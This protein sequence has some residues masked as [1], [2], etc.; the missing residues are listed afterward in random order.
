MTGGTAGDVTA[1]N[2]DA[3]IDGGAVVGTVTASGTVSVENAQ[4]GTLDG[5]VVNT[6]GATVTGNVEADTDASLT[7]GSVSGN[8]NVTD[9]AATIT[10]TEI[11]GTVTADSV[12]MTGGTAGAV[13]ADNGNATIDGG[14]VVGDVT[15]IGTVS[16]DNAAAGAVSAKD[17][18]LN[19]AVTGVVT[20]TDSAIISGGSVNGD[21]TA[22]AAMI[23]DAEIVGNVAAETVNMKRATTGDVTG[24]DVVIDLASRVDGSVNGKDVTIADSFISDSVSGDEVSLF[25]GAW[26]NGDVNA[27]ALYAEGNVNAAAISAD[28]MDLLD[29]ELVADSLNV[30]GAA[31]ISNASVTAETLAADSVTGDNA[32][33]NAAVT[34]G[35]VTLTNSSAKD[36]TMTG[37]LVASGSAIGSVSGAASAVITGGSTGDLSV[38]GD[39]TATNGADIAS[40]SNADDVTLAQAVTGDISATGKVNATTGT[41]MGDVTSGSAAMSGAK[42]KSL[43]TGALSV[44]SEGFVADADISADGVVSIAGSTTAGKSISLKGSAGSAISGADITAGDKLTLDGTI[45]AANT[46]LTGTNGVAVQ[47]TLDA[48]K[49][50]KFAGGAVTGTGTIN[51]TGGDTLELAGNTDLTGGAVN[52]D[53]STL[54]AADG[55][56]LGSVALKGATMSVAGSAIGSVT[57]DN[58]KSDAAGTLETNVDLAARKADTTVV[59][60]KVDL[61]GASIAM[62]PTSVVAE[63]SVADQTRINI[64]SGSVTSG[65]NEDV[66]HSMDTL[67]AHIENTADGVDLVLS[68]NYKGA[69]NKTQNQSATADALA[70]INPAGVP[71]DSPLA[72]VLDAL[73]HTRSEADAKLALDSLSGA[74]LAGLQ[75]AIAEDAK[76]HMQTLRAT[77]KAL[78][79]DVQR[80]YDENGIIPGVQSSAISASVTGGT[81]ELSGDENCGDYTRSSF[82]GMV[83]MAH[84]L[85]NGWTFGSSFAFSYADAECG[86]VNMDG[87]F[88]YVDLA[89]MHKG[90]RLTQTGT[91]GASFINFDTERDVRVNAPGHSFAGRAEGSTSAVAINMSYEMAYDLIKSDDGHRLGSVVMAEATFAQIDGMTESGLGNAGVNAEFDDVASLTFGIGARYT[92]EFGAKDNPGYFNLDVMAVAEAGDNT[93]KVNNMF[94]GGGQTYELVGPEAGTIGLRLNAGV[95]LP[96][97]QQT[98]IFGN[99]TSEFRSEQTSVGG[100]VG[101]KYSF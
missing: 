23:T 38:N 64:I 39:V 22:A 75:K 73:G 61:N 100:S 74:G 31:D 71:A 36:M 12:D 20:A 33:I 53:A 54:A 98:G 60:G 43:N 37:D 69:E 94:I 14:A 4:T 8:V 89:M 11:T 86:D 30:S 46:T 85:Y 41:V 48:G 83:A 6:N 90:K 82:G 80:R 62:A 99:V 77:M 34:A 65:A 18:I 21:V 51:K 10:G 9:G 79:A 57:A 70:S 16:V 27:G 3:T 26:I 5:A 95:L 55:A 72:D 24:D 40:I 96:I 15:A 29:G 76:E 87:E 44:A 7:G 68:K 56:K 91:I 97:G 52:V 28:S 17:V 1:D 47:G 67:N 66:T 45:S 88:I 42:A 32:V 84:A 25:D 101:V 49:G 63:G 93:P 81:A 59:S 92:Y 50:V 2:G 13:T 19:D 78:N 58:L 35:D